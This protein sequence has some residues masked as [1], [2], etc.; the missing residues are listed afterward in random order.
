MLRSAHDIQDELLVYR[1]QDGEADALRE[2][3][4]RWHGRLFAHAFRL[5]GQREE[6]ADAVQDAWLA[7]V[8]GIRRLD[9]P[10]RFRSW[11]YRIVTYKAI[12]RVRRA[13]RQRKTLR[14][15]AESSEVERIESRAEQTDEMDALRAGLSELSGDRRAILTMFY[16]ESMPMSEIAVALGIPVGTVKSRL[17]HAR[18][19][20]KET[21]EHRER[22]SHVRL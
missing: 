9:D 15:A 7:I 8:R 13:Q 18:L 17:H 20:L 5:T 22:K 3:V 4:E 19:T 1:C 16:L 14:V 2:L 12:D 21:L 6:A 11:A 10:A